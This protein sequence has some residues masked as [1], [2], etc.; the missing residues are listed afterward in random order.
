MSKSVIKSKSFIYLFSKIF[1]ALFQLLSIFLFTRI[2]STKIYGD[3]I[4]FSSYVMFICSFVFWWHRLSVYRYYHKF[5]KRY[6]TFIKTSYFSFYALCT[7]L[8]VIYLFLYI[9]SSTG[10]LK[11]SDIFLLSIL[12][13]TLRSI[14]DLNQNLLN[15][16]RDDTFFGLNII[17]RPLL[18]LCVC[19]FV[20]NFFPNSQYA[21][22]IGFISSFAISSI[23][24]SY[25]IQK[26]TGDGSFD[27]NIIKKFISYGF[28]LTGLFLFDYILTSS[29]RILIG[30]F[31]D[32]KMV[33]IYGANYDFIKQLILF[34]VIVQGLIIYPEINRTYE[35]GNQIELENLMSLN[36]NLLIVIIL[37]LSIF[38]AFFNEFITS[39]FIGDNFNYTS[40]LLIP[41]FSFMFFFWGLKIYHF[42][43]IFFLREKTRL[44]MKI[45]LFGSLI[46]ICLN[47]VFIPRYELMGAAFST[48]LAY[49][50]C[51]VLSFY[52]GRELMIVNIDKPIFLKALLFVSISIIITFVIKFMDFNIVYQISTFILIYSLLT[53]FF[54]S[55]ALKKFKKRF[56]Y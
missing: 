56:V 45:L 1:A 24:S 53:L 4:L 30:Y 51:L 5:K 34:L 18:F 43:Y 17:I 41:S 55:V 33:G 36:F 50:I 35:K 28:P 39:I 6:S 38:V 2:F 21:L 29:D 44:S 26:N 13:S 8:I 20:H 47:L 9:F 19:L 37:P 14:F 16:N 32:S 3:F 54:N 52:K 12:A 46:N 49:L 22:L 27:I 11:V 25:Y 42:D 48:L 23:F 40:S 31:F 10:F 15:I 7:F